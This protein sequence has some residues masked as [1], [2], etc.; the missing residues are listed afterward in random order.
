MQNKGFPSGCTAQH[1]QPALGCAS[2]CTA[3]ILYRVETR[4]IH[5]QEM[6]GSE[7]PLGWV[8]IF[9]LRYR[10]GYR[11]RFLSFGIRMGRNFCHRV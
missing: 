1:S 7:V 9:E 11:S 2:A 4:R 6:P 5:S 8:A 3:H 10:D